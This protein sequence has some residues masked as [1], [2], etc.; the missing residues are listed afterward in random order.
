MKKCPNSRLS[1]RCGVCADESR[2]SAHFI[3]PGIR[4]GQSVL[5]EGQIKSCQ[6][7]RLR[8]DAQLFLLLLFLHLSSRVLNTGSQLVLYRLKPSQ[9]E[10]RLL[11]LLYITLWF[12]RKQWCYFKLFLWTTTGI[13]FIVRGAFCSPQLGAIFTRFRLSLDQHHES[14]PLTWTE[15]SVAVDRTHIVSHIRTCSHVNTQT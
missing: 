14:S 2:L 9:L 1:S 5:A 3:Q 12:R 13:T 4:A 6:P 10:T 8:L 7:C 11:V 15:P